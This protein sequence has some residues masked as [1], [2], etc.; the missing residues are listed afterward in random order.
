MIV[1][2][3]LVVLAAAAAAAGVVV[4]VVLAAV[5]PSRS[6]VCLFV[7][8][9]GWLVGCLLVVLLLVLLHVLFCSSYSC[10]PVLAPLPFLVP[11]SFCSNPPRFV[12]RCLSRFMY[13]VFC[14]GKERRKI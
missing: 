12:S 4:V 10:V 14:A 11:S 8:L 1:R 6:V 3:L 2:V 7:C 5:V 9:V 13:H